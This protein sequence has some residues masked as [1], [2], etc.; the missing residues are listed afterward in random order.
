[1]SSPQTAAQET[2]L[3]RRTVHDYTRQ[4]LPE[5]ALERALECA[6]R[7]PNHKLT[8]PWRFTRLGPKARQALTLLALD[9][10][11]PDRANPKRVE[12]IRAKFTNPPEL[13][14]V[15]QLRNPQDPL[16]QKED[17]AAVACAI[18]NISLSLW[19][20][21][22]G[23]KWSSGGVT[24]HERT[25]ALAQIPEEEEVVGFVWMGYPE[26]VPNPPRAPLSAVLKQVE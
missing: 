18:Q 5:G 23:S 26:K 16:R 7:A 21:G 6:L 9:L 19:S 25:R 4:P 14:V 13:V 2:I 8:N 3:Q 22:V 17:Y 20:E 15:S 11:C 1:M 24:R 10:K 12:T